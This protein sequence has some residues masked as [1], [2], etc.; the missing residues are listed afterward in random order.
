MSRVPIIP[1]N[2]LSSSEKGIV[3]IEEERKTHRNTRSS[4]DFLS[5]LHSQNIRVRYKLKYD[6]LQEIKKQ[7]IT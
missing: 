4:V 6:D 2:G 7:E 1:F 3:E 5:K